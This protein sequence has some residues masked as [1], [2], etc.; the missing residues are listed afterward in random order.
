MP[1][2][3]QSHPPGKP[4]T[5]DRAKKCSPEI[6]TTGSSL[7]LNY[8]ELYI[9]IRQAARSVHA[10]AK[11]KN[12]DTPP[13]CLP[14]EALAKAGGEVALRS[15]DCSEGGRVGVALPT[16]SAPGMFDKQSNRKSNNFPMA[17]FFPFA[18][19]S[20]ATRSLQK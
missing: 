1:A 16:G 11:S 15:S 18:N 13:P 10:F 12:S 2:R 19:Q 9:A 6:F 5:N 7:Y 4:V 20:L 3:R 14:A 8:D 17:S